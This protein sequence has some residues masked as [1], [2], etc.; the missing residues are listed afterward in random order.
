[1]FFRFSNFKI[2][3]SYQTAVSLNDKART[4]KFSGMNIIDHHDF[5]YICWGTFLQI[6]CG[7]NYG[8]LITL[9]RG[10]LDKCDKKPKVLPF[11]PILS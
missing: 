11:A 7:L 5:I 1:M 9:E 2:F 10:K 4:Y 3:K 8:P 6:S